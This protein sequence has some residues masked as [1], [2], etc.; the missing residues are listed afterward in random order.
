M[1]LSFP[2][3]VFTIGACMIL[4]MYFAPRIGDKEANWQHVWIVVCL[5]VLLFCVGFAPSSIWHIISG[6]H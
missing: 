5:S 4:L 6:G 1:T 2:M 3:N